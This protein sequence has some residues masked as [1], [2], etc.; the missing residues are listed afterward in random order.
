M[1][2][3]PKPDS[4]AELRELAAR[5]TAL[6]AEPYAGHVTWR[7]MLSDVLDDIAQHRG[8]DV[9]VGEPLPAWPEVFQRR[10]SR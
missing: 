7:L 8:R 1:T 4:L 9:V 3:M 2:D 5:L 6:T 10:S